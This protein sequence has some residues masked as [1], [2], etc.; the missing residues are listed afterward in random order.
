MDTRTNLSVS[1]CDAR[2]SK[3]DKMTCDVPSVHACAT[4]KTE[5][6]CFSQLFGYYTCV[7][8]FPMRMW[9]L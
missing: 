4:V 2:A 3:E 7:T 1:L 5:L 9:Y 8:I 6:C